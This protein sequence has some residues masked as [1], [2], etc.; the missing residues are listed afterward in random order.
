MTKQTQDIIQKLNRCKI[1]AIPDGE[2]NIRLPDVKL[3][4][5]D[6]CIILPEKAMGAVV[7]EACLISVSMLDDGVFA[8]ILQSL[9]LTRKRPEDRN[10][11]LRK[12]K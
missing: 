12:G 9:F 5:E 7:D 1:T 2:G 3:P 8:N 6:V 4:G 11:D 10:D